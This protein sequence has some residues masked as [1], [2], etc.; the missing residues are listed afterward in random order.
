[1]LWYIE[2]SMLIVERQRHEREAEIE[3]KHS[4][5]SRKVFWVVWLSDT[6]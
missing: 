5:G 2:V 4:A 1:M 6:D 3:R